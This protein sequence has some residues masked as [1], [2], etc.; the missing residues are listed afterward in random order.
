VTFIHILGVILVLII[1]Y[2]VYVAYPL[3]HAKS[4]DATLVPASHAYSH[5]DPTLSKNILVIGDSTAVGVGAPAEQTIAALLSEDMKASV[6]NYA[7]SG[8][9]TADLAGQA[10]HAQRSHYDL[11]EIQI[12][13][14]DVIGFKSLSDAAHS[15][16]TILTTLQKKSDHIVLLTA[17]DIGTS[18]IFK[19]P[20]SSIISSRTREL[21]TLFMNI[22]AAHQVAYVDIY[23]KP[24]TIAA[25]PARY[26]AA[27]GLHL[28]AEGY[29]YWYSLIRADIIARPD[30]AGL[31]ASN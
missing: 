21:R 30:F 3:L 13:A 27:D 9:V 22:C 11:I 12:G 4:V 29:A 18:P 31:I 26:H 1:G 28:N 23:S 6:E 17:G 15:L 5:I 2:T 8:A 20:L 14:N 10:A 25:D 7:V 24:D 16:D 19:W